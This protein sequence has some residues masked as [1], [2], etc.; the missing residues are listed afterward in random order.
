MSVNI[1]FSIQILPGGW[2]NM[3]LHFLPLDALL[4]VHIIK[5]C[6]RRPIAGS[7]TIGPVTTQF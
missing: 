6:M 5:N 2:L 4:K 7:Q 3:R 1:L